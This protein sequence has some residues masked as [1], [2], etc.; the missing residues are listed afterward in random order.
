MRR[1]LPERI[2]LVTAGEIDPA[3]SLTSPFRYQAAEGYAAMDAR[4][5]TKVLLTM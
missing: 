2:E 4:R 1:F 5:T 3:W